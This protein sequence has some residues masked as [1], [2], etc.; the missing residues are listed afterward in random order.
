[1][2][3][4]EAMLKALVW[5]LFGM[6][7]NREEAKNAETNVDHHTKHVIVLARVAAKYQLVEDG[8]HEVVDW[9]LHDDVKLAPTALL[10]STPR[11]AGCWRQRRVR[12]GRT[13]AAVAWT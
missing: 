13:G 4:W 1:M 6:A 8:T 5:P 10:V 12:A 11:R 7:Q 9:R 3:S 2:K